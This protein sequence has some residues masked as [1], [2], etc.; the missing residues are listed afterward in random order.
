[1]SICPICSG[2]S[3]A[4]LASRE[5]LEQECRVRATFVRQR[6]SHPVSPGEAKDLTDFFHAE[7]AEI[8]KCETCSLLMRHE[9]ER[10]PALEY[11]E[12][13]YDPEVIGREYPEY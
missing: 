10:P 6:L 9:Y 11:S 7:Q 5:R 2:T 12:D 3:F 1:M 4:R 8:D 13:E